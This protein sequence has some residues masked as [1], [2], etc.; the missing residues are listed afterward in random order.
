MATLDQYM[1]AS[2][3]GA[4]KIRQNAAGWY[5]STE[6]EIDNTYNCFA[7]AVGVTH[8][9]INAQTRAQLDDECEQEL[10]NIPIPFRHTWNSN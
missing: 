2:F 6:E 7:Y 1:T 5:Q 10:F 9:R 3:A 4:Q 8:R